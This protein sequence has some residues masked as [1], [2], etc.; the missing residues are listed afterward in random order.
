MR[1]MGETVGCGPTRETGYFVLQMDDL[2]W[3][4]ENPTQQDLP[5]LSLSFHFF[6]SSSKFKLES[7]LGLKSGLK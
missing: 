3:I 4:T 5:F 1:E 2:L 6:F 7:N